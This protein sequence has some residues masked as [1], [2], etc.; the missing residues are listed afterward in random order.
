MSHSLADKKCLYS[1][2]AAA[3]A[4]EASE[5]AKIALETGDA[6]LAAGE[7]LS[8]YLVGFVYFYILTAKYFTIRGGS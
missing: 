4:A 6:E 5:K 1:V 2:Q 7:C 3:A 8:L